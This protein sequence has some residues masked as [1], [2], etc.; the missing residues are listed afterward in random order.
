MSSL[1]RLPVPTPARLAIRRWRERRRRVRF[2]RAFVPPGG[3]CFDIGANVGD[4]VELFL[5]IPARVVAV[6]PQSSCHSVLE[7]RFGGH[8]RFTLERSALGAN[9]G[10]AELMAADDYETSVL[11]TLSRDWAASVQ[12]SGRFASRRWERTEVVEVV[13]LD[14]LVDRYGP[15]DF[16][17]IDVEGYEPEVLAGLSTPIPS[18]SVEF[19][20]ERFEATQT[21]VARLLELGDYGFNHSFGESLALA[22]T[23]WV[24]ADELLTALEAFRDDSSTFGDVYARL[25]QPSRRCAA[26]IRARTRLRRTSDSKCTRFPPN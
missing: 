5:A 11:A 9:P 1:Q 18:L 25:R 3:L 26:R 24:G 2:Y 7:A 23:Q 20:P 12:E 13:T 22:S 16:C 6:E 19:T 17:K 4:R 10:E 21:C 15:P 14:S 8:P